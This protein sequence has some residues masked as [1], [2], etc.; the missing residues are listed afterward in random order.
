MF[1]EHPKEQELYHSIATV[2][3]LLLQIGEVGKK[4]YMMKDEEESEN[5]LASRT[6]NLTLEEEASKSEDKG[7][8]Q[9]TG[10]MEKD[11]AT[12][13]KSEENKEAAGADSEAGQG[14]VGGVPSSQSISSSMA[15]S[16]SYVDLYWSVTF[17]QFLASMLTEQ[18]LVEFFEERVDL[19][20][21]IEKFRN[22]RL[23]DRAN[24]VSGTS[25]M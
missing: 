16:A 12:Q 24:S 7:D 22:R 3:T 20:K 18:M 8:S 19:S 2:G 15:S 13:D 23:Y 1:L 14:A 10:S 9:A 4:F 5:Q 21:P 25:P 17:E 6:E 11:A